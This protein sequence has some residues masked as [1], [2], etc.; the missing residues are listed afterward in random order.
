[1]A[2]ERGAAIE[3]AKGLR[4]DATAATQTFGVLARKRAGKTYLAGKLVEELRR[5]GC[6][7][8]VIDP[9]GNWWGLTLAA[10]GKDP[11]LPFI[12]LGGEKGDIPL[13]PDAGHRLA[14]FV[15][16]RRLSSVL[17][18]SDFDDEERARFVSD[19]LEQFLVCSKKRRQVHMMV[20]EEVHLI[21]PER[22]KGFERALRKVEK[23]V[24]VGGNY[25]TGC[26]LLSQRPQSVNKEVLSQVE[27]LFVG[28]L[29]EAHG[30]KSIRYWVVEKGID[31]KRRIDEA[32]SLE[33][34]EFFCW[35]P[36]WLQ[37]FKKVKIL[38]K[39]TFDGSRTPELGD[40]PTSVEP[41]KQRLTGVE[42]E[43]LKSLIAAG[44]KKEPSEG[45]EAV[46]GRLT[47]ERARRKAAELEAGK[48]REQLAE[49][50]E[51]LVGVRQ[52]LDELVAS[53]AGVGAPAPA[54][55]AGVR[56]EARAVPVA[57]T[58]SRDTLG[59]RDRAPARGTVM[60]GRPPAAAAKGI[61]DAPDASPLDKCQRAILTALVQYG[62][63]PRA[64]L[65]LLSGY[66]ARSSSMNNALSKLRTA[67]RIEG[68]GDALAPT[69]VGRNAIG[70]IAP[71]PTGRALFEYWQRH[72]SLDKCSRALV[73]A[74]RE[75][76]GPL[77]KDELAE[78]SGYSA[79]SSSMNNGLSRLRT[80]GLIEGRGAV[81][82]AEDLR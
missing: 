80:L 62:R 58:A 40:M 13:S 25:G 33:P 72:P 27:C 20:F 12:V 63:L 46:D 1:M 66:S 57:R 51:R 3:I 18:V 44:T 23:V 37:V 31:V 55:A 45:A 2:S 64:R 69:V 68:R 53:L 77:G 71:L 22:H 8:T 82:L 17:D 47:E 7:V 67:G 42:L 34:G 11:G 61:N 24:R 78:R 81:M 19:F 52:R 38:P 10:N 32:A 60:N 76:G 50:Q 9:V 29:V 75:A 6:P 36:V 5:V 15:V 41:R 49:Q 43:A 14:E 73:G 26:M 65:A 56:G 74:L 4:F 39:W 70:S 54:S 35:S 79:S 16:E 21:A 28:Q 59:S 30:R 48:L